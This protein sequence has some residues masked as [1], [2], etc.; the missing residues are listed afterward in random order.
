MN[1]D[2]TYGSRP[3][4]KAILYCMGEVQSVFL[5]LLSDP[6]S[7]HLSRESCCLGIAA[8]HGIIK[9]LPQ[10][11]S[12][13]SGE[14]T[15][16]LSLRL[17]HAF[18]QTTNY[19]GNVFFVQETRE[20]AEQRRAT[21]RGD[22]NSQQTPDIMEPF[23]VG[24]EAGGT[25]N[26]GEAQLGAY[27]EMAAASVALKRPDVLYDLL[28]LSVSHHVWFTVSSREKYGATALIGGGLNHSKMREALQPHLGKLLPKILR[29]CN[30][31]N[32]QTR[33]QMSSLL[34][35]L[36]GGGAETRQAISIHLVEV[37]DVLL[38]DSASKFWRARVGACGALSDV[39]V[40]RDWS[41]LGGG[42]PML[43]DDF[44]Y[45]ASRTDAGAAVRLLRLWRAVLRS[46]DDVRDAVRQS[47]LTLGRAVR[48]LTLRLCD[49]SAQN[50]SSGDKR[51]RDD[52]TNLEKDASAAAA[53][54]VRWLVKHGL[55][56]T[57][58]ESQGLCVA[59]L[60]DVIGIAKPVILEPSLPE[61][62]RSLLLAL[63]GLEPAAFNYLQL[64]AR[65]QEGLERARLQIAQSGPIAAAVNKCVE[66]LP[67]AKLETQ[68]EVVVALDSALRL[69]SGFASRGAVADT[70]ALMCNICPGA[71]T[72][73][74]LSGNAS[75]SVRLMRAF[76][77]ASEKERGQ[78]AKDKMTHALGN[79][80]AFCPGSS[81]RSLALR[82]CGR[83]RASTGSHN[84]PLSRR[85]A[86][87]S[88]RAI[89]VRATKQLSDGGNSDVWSQTV[90]PIAFL[91][92]KDEESKVASLMKEVW[93]EGGSA[94]QE[95]VSQ[96]FGT[97]VE[98]VLL[99][100]LVRE[101]SRALEDLSF[102]RRVAGS[103]SLTELCTLGVLSPLRV[104]GTR[105]NTERL[106][107]SVLLRAKRRAQNCNIAVSASVRLLKKPRLWTGK[108]EV[109]AETVRLIST[110]L[111]LAN[112]D[113]V[114]ELL[115]FEGNDHDCPWRPLSFGLCHDILLGDGAFDENKMHEEVSLEV[116]DTTE[117]TP[118]D[119]Y[120]ENAKVDFD[121]MDTELTTDQ[122]ASSTDN[123]DNEWVALSFVG[124]CRFLVEEALPD[125]PSA[126][127]TLSEEFLPYRAAGLRGFRD[128]IK[129]LPADSGDSIKRLVFESV[130]DRLLAATSLEE[131]VESKKKKTPPVLVAASIECIGACL[132]KSFPSERAEQL[133]TLLQSS[134]GSGQPAWT[135]R[136]ASATALSHMATCCEE[137]F[138]RKPSV[139]SGLIS[140]ASW[141]LQDR[142]FW[143]VRVA[144]LRLVKAMIQRSG[145][146]TEK[147]DLALEALLPYKENL[148]KLL[149]K[150]LS[151]SEPNVT[152]LSSET[153]ILM[154]W[155]P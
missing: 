148:Q 106:Q 82:A 94:V 24:G 10:S 150:A 15:Q 137:S 86:A 20:Q 139:I 80:A 95:S 111:P 79:I 44:L 56:Q 102:S 155:W 97:R 84:D 60:V 17:L 8:C 122:A 131:S 52:L 21:E 38:N 53:T 72:F 68:Q 41:E 75:P 145:T 31:P 14:T 117:P 69:S 152:S 133:I 50:K 29:A 109:V 146:A 11:I 22:Q 88:L 125:S 5:G 62:I 27:R 121:A 112:S 130:A 147:V 35:G 2:P 83:Y 39:I 6:K 67:R 1:T 49:P 16:S 63:S 30:D 61:L 110:W 25:A 46:L 128:M 85:A 40:G 47:G 91:G 99:P 129:K 12:V 143:K 149:R 108:S 78:A 100:E 90:L 124:F 51:S 127:L 59:T 81:V 18:G 87:G 119:D 118:P 7:K 3:L 74:G 65:D 134:G 34:A 113:G 26:M 48:A 153:I 101:C 140:A 37:V 76:Y 32:K 123:G 64:R 107:K 126:A 45:D 114:S 93:Q 71:F 151:D 120:D 154:S 96:E 98:E 66:L 77:F 103:K 141:A 89:V 104:A 92:Q 28:L 58:P 142:K 19:G 144:G 136:E 9:A 105:D 13:P 70:A 4:T 132:W 116:Q 57:V 23:G 33:E 43:E 135:I 54:A 55:T 138:F 115:G 73:P 36:T 42:G